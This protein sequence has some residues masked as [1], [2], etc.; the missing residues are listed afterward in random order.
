MADIAAVFHWPPDAMDAMEP[1]E[2][3]RWHKLAVD[4]AKARAKAGAL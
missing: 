2:L 1:K 4:I 3:R